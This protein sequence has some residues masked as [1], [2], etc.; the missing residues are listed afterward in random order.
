MIYIS[1]EGP[2]IIKILIRIIMIV[3]ISDR[4][5]VHSTYSNI[6]YLVHFYHGILQNWR[7]KVSVFSE[8]FQ[9]VHSLHNKWKSC[10]VWQYNVNFVW[11]MI[12]LLFRE[13]DSGSGGTFQLFGD[14][15]TRWV[16]HPKTNE[17]SSL[18]VDCEE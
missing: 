18:R 4:S 15:H 13:T 9:E 7:R 3:R 5:I 16:I 14:I 1:T 8:I 17:I 12:T 11:L 10:T 2:K 6:T